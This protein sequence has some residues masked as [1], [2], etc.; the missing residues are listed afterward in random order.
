MATTRTRPATLPRPLPLLGHALRF[1]RQPLEFIESLRP[2]GDIVTIR[3][4]V[5]PAYIVNSPDLLRKVL[6]AEAPAF[7]IGALLDKVRPFI[8]N[9][10]ITL[11]G[12][13]HRRHRRMLQPA[14]HHTRIARYA[15]VMRRPA[16]ARAGACRAAGERP[17]RA[18]RAA[19][20]AAR[21]AARRGCGRPRT[22]GSGNRSAR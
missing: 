14:F 21:R 15:D 16:T 20:R 3:L 9:G 4:G 18:G 2:F 8:G 6:V 10:L 22:G 17:S 19:G 13:T 11:R 5:K 12:A 7:E 1:R